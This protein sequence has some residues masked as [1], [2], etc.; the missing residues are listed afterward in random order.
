MIGNIDIEKL[1]VILRNI[2]ISIFVLI[3]LYILVFKD[4][5]AFTIAGSLITISSQWLLARSA[6]KQE[7]KKI[8]TL[9]I[10]IIDNQVNR[11]LRIEGEIMSVNNNKT[12]LESVKKYCVKCKPGMELDY[13]NLLNKTEIYALDIAGGIVLYMN[14]VNQF[15]D[16]LCFRKLDDHGDISQALID[17]RSYWIEGY[18]NAMKL[19]KEVVIDE[20][21]FNNCVSNLKREYQRLSDVKCIHE[22]QGLDSNC[23]SLIM[24]KI[25]KIF[26]T[27]GI[28]N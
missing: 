28:P 26:N 2:I 22:K 18:S 25:E 20:T 24:E 10:T 6:R 5:L 8:A 4:K 7:H 3:C 17:V 21:I 13:Q 12:H 15:F 14:H 11:L 23:E 27:F 1:V 9:M 16:Y 19:S